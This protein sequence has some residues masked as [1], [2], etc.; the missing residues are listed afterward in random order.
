MTDQSRARD[1]IIQTRGDRIQFQADQADAAAPVYYEGQGRIKPL[2]ANTGYR[3]R[4]IQSNAPLG[5]GDRIVEDGGLV[6]ATPRDG[7]GRAV[8]RQVSILG[9]RL[10]AA[11]RSLTVEDIDLVIESGDDTYPVITSS[12]SRYTVL[13]I[14]SSGIGTGTLSPAIGEEIAVGSGLNLS[15][16]GNDN[17]RWSATIRLRRRV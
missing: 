3:A 5:T 9:N 8:V 10:A 12:S 1:R 14:S 13:A 7:I 4:G 6:Q 17:T 11:I 16:V 15:L 2:G